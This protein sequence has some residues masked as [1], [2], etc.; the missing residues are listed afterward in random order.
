MGSSKER[1]SEATRRLTI[2]RIQTKRRMMP[3]YFRCSRYYRYCRWMTPRV[4]GSVPDRERMLVD[5]WGWADDDLLRRNRQNMT[6]CPVVEEP[7]LSSWCRPAHP[8]TTVR[9][10]GSGPGSSHCQSKRTSF[11]CGYAAVRNFRWNQSA[12]FEVIDR[13]RPASCG[14]AVESVPLRNVVTR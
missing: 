11:E 12:S 6:S 5:C 7:G 8:I 10:C 9:F 3:R 4:V 14:A 13:I 2:D 1:E